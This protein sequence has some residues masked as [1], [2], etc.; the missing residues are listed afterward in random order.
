MNVYIT[1]QSKTWLIADKLETVEMKIKQGL[2]FQ[3]VGNWYG[4]LFS[5]LLK[6]LLATVL[7]I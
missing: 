4:K 6:L 3:I 5:L 1:T 2:N 7:Q